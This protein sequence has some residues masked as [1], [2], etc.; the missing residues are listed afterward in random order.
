[1]VFEGW[2]VWNQG[3][4]NT[5]WNSSQRQEKCSS[6]A[7]RQEELSLIQRRVSHFVLLKTSSDWEDYPRYRGQPA[8]VI[9][10]MDMLILSKNN[11]METLRI[12]LTMYIS[13]YPV[14]QSTHKITHHLDKQGWIQAYAIEIS[15]LLPQ[16]HCNIDHVVESFGG[17]WK[18][19]SVITSP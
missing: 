19:Y 18:K 10:P 12:T 9:L 17:T 7:I 5:S 3:R 4:V 15:V 16:N 2:Q 14:T 6:K 8:L 1:M 13:G 11:L